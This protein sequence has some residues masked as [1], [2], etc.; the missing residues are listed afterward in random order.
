[1]AEMIKCRVNGLW[2]IILPKH[3]ADRPEW[4]TEKGWEKERL[5]NMYGRIDKGDMVYYVGG[6]ENEMP[7]LITKWGG[8]VVIFEPNFRVWPNGKAIWKANNLPLPKACFVGFA[9]DKCNYALGS[10][11]TDGW[12]VCA[13]GDIIGDHG[14][15][16]LR[17][18]NADEITIDEMVR[19]THL[20]PKHISI[21]TEG[22]EGLILRGAEQTLR[23]HKPLIWLS[24]HPEFCHEQ[25]GEYLIEIREWIKK[26]GYKETLLDYSHEVHLL[27]TPI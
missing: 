13:D 15:M 10:L 9:S 5:M 12:P 18:H 21:D 23:N 14:F 20:I 27:Y 17:N 1:M 8:E 25:Y 24:G 6:E 11:V 16:E 7:A 3:R 4:Y 22:S 19:V 26:I 2:D